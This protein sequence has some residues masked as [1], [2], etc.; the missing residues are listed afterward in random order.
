MAS[1]SRETASAIG[2]E[3]DGAVAPGLAVGAGQGTSGAAVA[4]QLRDDPPVKATVRM[5]AAENEIE[6]GGG[7][8]R[9]APGDRVRIELSGESA[10]PFGAGPHACP[11][12][13]QATAIAI[14]V[15]EALQRMRLQTAPVEYEPLPN[16]RI[17][18][19]LEVNPW[20]QDDFS[21]LTKV[22]P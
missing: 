16:L 10:L 22:A 11:G 4:A 6:A 13:E 21:P 14:G 15:C 2:T 17:P 7:R 9:L 8:V 3:S 1:T 19:R 18:A 12:R 20:P 5:A